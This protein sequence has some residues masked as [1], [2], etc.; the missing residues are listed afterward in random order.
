MFSYIVNK[1]TVRKVGVRKRIWIMQT[2]QGGT[3]VEQI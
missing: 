1:S 2:N 3:K